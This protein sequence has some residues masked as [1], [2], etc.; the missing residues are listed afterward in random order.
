M[1]DDRLVKHVLK[2]QFMKG[3][4]H[5]MMLDS[6]DAETFEDLVCKPPNTGHVDK[7]SGINFSA[8]AR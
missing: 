1:N 7:T 5:N 4:R 3:D 6:P 8:H 2:V